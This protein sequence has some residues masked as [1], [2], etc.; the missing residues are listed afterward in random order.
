MTTKT[1]R[2][3]TFSAI[4]QDLNA[5]AYRSRQARLERDSH[6]VN[7]EARMMARIAVEYAE[8]EITN[9]KAEMAELQKA[10]RP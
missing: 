3:R 5:A 4:I 1:A 6:P 8:Q 2:L 10:H 9:L 7:T